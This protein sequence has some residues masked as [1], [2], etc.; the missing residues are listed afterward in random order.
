MSEGFNV[1]TI[2]HLA[3]Q[4]KEPAWLTELRR[5]AWAKHG[6]LPWPHP[7]DDIWRRTDVSLL[8]PA[9]GFSPRPPSLLQAI[10]LAGGGP[11]LAR[12]RRA[13]SPARG[14]VPLAEE[15]SKLRLEGFALGTMGQDMTL[16]HRE[17]RV[18]VLL[19]DPGSGE[20]NTPNLCDRHT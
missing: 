4:L 18:P 6:Q 2:D 7:S 5:Q 16:Q 1:T 10:P 12:L 11:L 14:G 9:Q 13:I 20:G 3:T 8:D 15:R 19:G 17:H